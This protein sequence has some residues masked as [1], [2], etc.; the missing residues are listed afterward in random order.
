MDT[1]ASEY[2]RHRLER[3]EASID[4]ASAGLRDPPASAPY[5]EQCAIPALLDSMAGHPDRRAFQEDYLRITQK[6]ETL[7]RGSGPVYRTR[8][9]DDL[10]GLVHVYH[11]SACHAGICTISAEAASDPCRRRLISILLDELRRDH[12]VSGIEALLSGIDENL[13]LSGIAGRLMTG[14]APA[15][16]HANSVEPNPVHESSRNDSRQIRI[17]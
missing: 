17:E 3:Y 14:E 8:L 6:L 15:G 5:A 13:R 4:R 10:T 9:F 16:R 11:A 12:D 1:T 2:I 7:A